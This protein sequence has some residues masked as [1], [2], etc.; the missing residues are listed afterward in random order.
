MSTRQSLSRLNGEPI[1]RPNERGVRAS[2]DQIDRRSQCRH[3]AGSVRPTRPWLF[4]A[5]A[6]R[7]RQ[8]RR[9]MVGVLMG[10]R[11]FEATTGRRWAAIA[12]QMKEAAN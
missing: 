4:I 6:A 7:H 5:G 1:L 3:A 9:S 10:P 8:G 2:A 12:A 11:R